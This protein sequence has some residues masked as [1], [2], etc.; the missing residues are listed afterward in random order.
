MESGVLYMKTANTGKRLK[1]DT[2]KT[3]KNFEW[4]GEQE[5]GM[6]LLFPIQELGSFSRKF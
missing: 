4:Y 2:P 5:D 1:Q 3:Y 6:I